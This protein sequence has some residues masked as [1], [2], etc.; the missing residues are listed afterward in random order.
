[1]KEVKEKIRLSQTT[2]TVNNIVAGIV[3]ICHYDESTGL[4]YPLPKEI[5][6]L[7]E[8]FLPGTKEIKD[9]SVTVAA[10]TTTGSNAISAPS[11]YVFYIEAITVSGSP[12]SG[13][14]SIIVDGIAIFKDRA[15]TA[16]TIDILS[17]FGKRI[18]CKKV[19]I[20]VTLDSA[21]T[22]DTTIS[23]SATVITRKALI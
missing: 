23:I 6:A 20:V 9:V 1:M 11:G 7:P 5:G 12:P 21:P 18:R 15:L 16:E 10:D 17:E 13:K 22:S 19:E 4:Y 2:F 14:Y 8:E 3:G